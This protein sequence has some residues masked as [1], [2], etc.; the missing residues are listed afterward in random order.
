MS[1]LFRCSGK[2]RLRLL[3]FVLVL[4][5]PG[6]AAAR[7]LPFNFFES[8][9]EIPFIVHGKVIHSNGDGLVSAN[10]GVDICKHRFSIQVIEVLKGK[11]EEQTLQVSYDFVNQ[12]PNISLFSFGQ[13]YIFAVRKISKDGKATL[14]GNTCGRSGLSIDYLDKV[15]KVLGRE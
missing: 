13:E 3:I 5:G 10:C 11:T 8:I 9:F 14:L 6:S 15:K 1:E 2:W 4:L 12:R 7:C